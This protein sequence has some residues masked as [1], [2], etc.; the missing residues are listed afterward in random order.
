MVQAVELRNDGTKAQLQGTSMFFFRTDV[1]FRE[2]DNPVFCHKVS[3]V[4]SRGY[5]RAELELRTLT[6]P[7]GAEIKGTV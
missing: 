2:S 5:K 4:L 6:D 7:H 3:S 1:D